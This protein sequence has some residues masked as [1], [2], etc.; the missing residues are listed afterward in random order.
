MMVE[1]LL[2]IGISMVVLGVVGTI[3][4][5]KLNEYELDSSKHFDS[6]IAW[7]ISIGASSV[8]CSFIVYVMELCG[9]LK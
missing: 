3:A 2:T 9:C 1:M 8:L 7:I 4:E 6:F 5:I